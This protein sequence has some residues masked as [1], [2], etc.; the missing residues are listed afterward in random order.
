MHGHW[1]MSQAPTVDRVRLKTHFHMRHAINP[2][3]R[4]LGECLTILKKLI[5]LHRADSSALGFANGRHARRDGR[6]NGGP[7]AV[8]FFWFSPPDALSHQINPIRYSRHL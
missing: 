2:P 6:A 8:S 4:R 3:I 1:H 7:R 5:T